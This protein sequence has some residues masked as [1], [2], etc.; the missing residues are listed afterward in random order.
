MN[1]IRAGSPTVYLDS[2]SVS[3]RRL[4]EEFAPPRALY[5]IHFPAI[6]AL[7]ALVSWI[8]GTEMAMVA[9]AG[10]AS[11][12]ALYMLW[13]WLLREGPTRLSTLL[14]LTLL[15]GYG[16]GAL[17]TWLTLPR[18]HL[19]LAAFLGSDEGV[20]ARGMAGVLLSA[21]PL[22]FFGELYER[23]L[24]G[25]EFRVPLDQHTYLLVL[26]GTVATVLGFMTNSLGYMGAQNVNGELSVPAAL[27]S[28]VF[29]PL[30][31]LTI[32]I[33]LA[34]PAGLPK[35]LTAA[36]ALVL[37]ACLMIV[38]RRVIV[39]AAM[40]TLFA[41]RLTGYQLKGTVFKKILLLLG[42]GLTITVGVTVF[43]LIRLAGFENPHD[44]S[45]LSLGHRID[46]AMGWVNDGTALTRATEANQTNVQKRTFVLGFFADLLEGSSRRTPGLGHDLFEYAQSTIPRVIY[47]EKD[48]FFSEEEYADGL[49]GLTYGDAANSILTNGAIDFG[50]LGV[51][52]YPLLLVALTR[53]C[54][55][56]CSRFLPALP[57]SIIALG[58][59]FTMLETETGTSGYIV[60]IRN[61]I[62][63]AVILFI[64]SR[65][66]KFQLRRTL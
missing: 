25:R 37:L 31:A 55:E 18:G 15:L 60:T 51:I 2:P 38:G 54:I 26:L 28:W 11:V 3:Y 52:V 8:A 21:A 9:A 35:L 13:D 47:P 1:A 36:C 49:F 40:E 29:P 44:P 53:I 56:V 20:L 10:V 59:I 23:P 50:L 48:A 45:S 27:L 64:Y 6:L 32:A 63:F 22:C 16:L 61:Q 58:T 14:A 39:Y 66:P 34:A 7:S 41:L 42:L 43:M 19:S 33:F 5:V 24:F 57:A 4:G 17:N 62:I 65:L 12:I 46:T 30:T